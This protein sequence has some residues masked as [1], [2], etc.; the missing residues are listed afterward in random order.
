MG[1]W[2]RLLPKIVQLIA[3]PK[4]STQN[5]AT[6]SMI[7]L[8]SFPDQI[9]Y[10]HTVREKFDL[11]GDKT[12]ILHACTQ[13]QIEVKHSTVYKNT[14]SY[15]CV[16]MIVFIYRGSLNFKLE[17]LFNIYDVKSAWYKLVLCSHQF[18]HW[19]TSRLY[20]LYTESYILDCHQN[21]AERPV[22]WVSS[23]QGLSSLCSL[24][25]F[26]A[27]SSCIFK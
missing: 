19:W 21:I 24:C 2:N 9:F 22:P 27:S 18:I 6:C 20:T 11:H 7:L 17:P 13:W 8:V 26:N 16:N 4:S 25:H 5:K 23:S 14:L 10:V 12:K 15:I 1:G 3:I